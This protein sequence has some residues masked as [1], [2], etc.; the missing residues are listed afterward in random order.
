MKAK[1]N[2]PC[3]YNLCPH[4]K[5]I[6][7]GEEIT[8][9]RRSNTGERYHVDCFVAVKGLSEYAPIARENAT[10]AVGKAIS[11]ESI[12]ALEIEGI[13]EEVEV[14]ETKE[15][16]HYLYPLL[17]HY[18]EVRQHV[19]LWGAPG[20]GKSHVARQIAKSLKLEFSFVSVNPQSPASLLLGYMD[21]NG[22]YRESELFKR[23][24]DGGVFLFDEQ[25]NCSSSLLTILNGML[26][27]DVAS[28]PCGMVPKHQDF[29]FVG[30]GNTSGR[31]G[32]WQFPERRKIDEASIDRLA[33]VQ[34]GYDEALELALTL[35]VN[36]NATAWVRWIQSVRAYVSNKANGVK[37]G[38]YCTPRS[39]MAGARDLQKLG[40]PFFSLSEIAERHVWK[41]T[42]KDLVN[43][44]IANCPLPK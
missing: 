12:A 15:L 1:Q 36:P 20:S 44:I 34:W 13:E 43:R 9:N 2:H 16:R 3:S 35:E 25:D 17:Q 18:V 8:W 26:A 24:R 10:H 6:R 31:G 14:P 37:G 19:Y 29:I 22:I 5:V 4:G 21:A 23:W 33:F 30:T 7:F 42:D 40:R 11:F 27:S 39:S 41:G 38:V 32:D 28:F